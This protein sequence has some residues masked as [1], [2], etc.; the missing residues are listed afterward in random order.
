MDL[1]IRLQKNFPQLLLTGVLITLICVLSLSSEYFLSWENFRNI[2]DQSS[3]HIL[4][5]VGM[6]F[7]IAGGGIDLSVGNV[8]AL[9]GVVMAVAM[10]AN[11][12]VFPAIVMG[13]LAAFGFGL[14]N[15]LVV[16]FIKVNPFITTLASMSVARGLALILTGGVSIYGFSA[17]FKFWGTGSIGPI[18]PPI[19]LSFIFAAL[20]LFLMAYTL[21]GKY[22]LALGGNGEALRIT[23]VNVNFYRTSIYCFSAL[24]AAT[25][26]LIM[27]ARLN[28]AAPLAGAT[29]EMDAIAAVVL[30][31]TSM[32]GGKASVP[33]TFI[34]CL[35]LGVMRNGLTMLAVPT[36][37]QQLFT[38][39]IILAAIV[40]SQLRSRQE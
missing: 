18:N 1:S 36:Y 21:W 31:G 39:V 10:K 24:C 9:S 12:D 22:S 13:Y 11:T 5:A 28:A 7:V 32:N 3:V 8:A 30:G 29:Y 25:A 35:T 2:L 34:A 37:Y 4:L 17:N 14:I 15:G 40:I 19:L 20:G 33:G 16:S 27:T 38:G 26:G 6:T 23:G